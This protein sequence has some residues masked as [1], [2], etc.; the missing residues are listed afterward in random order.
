[1]PHLLLFAPCQKAILDKGDNSLSIIGVMHG[2]VANLSAIDPKPLP[3]NAVAPLVWSAASI[4]LRTPEDEGKAFEQKVDVIDPNGSRFDSNNASLFKMTHRTHHITING[5][6]FPIAVAG[7]YKVVLSLREVGQEEW[8]KIIEYPVEIT[9][10]EG[11]EDMN[12]QV[13]LQPA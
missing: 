9:H 11:K 8:R 5:A 2:L 6:G 12:E 3:A 13:S 7:E 10:I 4:W 1:M